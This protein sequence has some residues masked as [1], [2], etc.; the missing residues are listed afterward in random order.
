MIRMNRRIKRKFGT[1]DKWNEAFSKDQK[2]DKNGNVSV[3]Q[4]KDFV[5]HALEDDIMDRKVSKRDIEGFL[6]AFNY[7]M[8]G[9]TNATDASNLIFTKDS[10]I[11][12]K[13][14][15]RF[16]ANAPP[17]EL[18]SGINPKDIDEKDVHNHHIKNL[19]STMENKVFDGKVKMFQVFRKFD[20][21]H[22]GYMSYE[23]FGKC[24]ESIKMD[25]SKDD[26]AKMLKLIDKNNTG[27]LTF[28]DFSKVFKPTM[29]DQLVTV[30]KKDSYLPNL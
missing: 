24:L 9:A 1:V 26:Q 22:D 17:E 25:V 27:Y 3:D 21:D 23:D 29:S 7:N 16:R 18:S 13:L 12:T 19:L 6:S 15:H 2:P 10:E 28:T 4:L 30:P 20:Q 5:L 14:A 8:Y 11:Q